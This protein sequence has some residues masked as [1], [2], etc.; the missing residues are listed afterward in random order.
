MSL[1]VQCPFCGSY[2][3]AKTTNGKVSNSV[4][5]A[6]SVI[7][8]AV[9]QMFTGIPGIIGPNVIIG[10]TWHQYCCHNCQE[11]FKVRFGASGDVKEIKKY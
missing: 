2:N 8:G 9:L 4:T 10:R 7:G 5:T 6:A 3:T 1:Q 11:V